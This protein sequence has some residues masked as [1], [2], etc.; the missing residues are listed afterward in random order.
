MGQADETEWVSKMVRGCKCI[1]CEGTDIHFVNHYSNNPDGTLHWDRYLAPGEIQ[2]ADHSVSPP[3][4]W[5]GPPG[6]QNKVTTVL[7]GP[8]AAIKVTTSPV[9]MAPPGGMV[10]KRC[11][12]RNEYAGPNQSDG[13]YLCYGCRP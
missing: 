10:C 11:S 12:I 3:K 7:T 8:V 13:K 5:V 9:R 6:C 1:Y 4:R 2:Y